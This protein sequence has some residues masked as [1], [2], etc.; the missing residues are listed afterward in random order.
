VALFAALACSGGLLVALQWDLTFI[1]DEWEFLLYRRGTSPEVLLNPHNEHIVLAPVTVYKLLVVSFGMESPLP[2]Q[3]VGD[4]VFLLS[5]ALLFAV[6]RRAAGD[7]L[8]LLG[9]FLV[10]FL[11]PAWIDLLW[12]F[13]I[14]Y[15][16]SIAAGLG[17]LLA[18]QRDDRGGDRAACLLLA[19]SLSFS[20]LGLCFAAAALADLALGPRRRAERAYVPLLPLSLFAIWWLGWGHKAETHLSFDNFLGSPGF[21]FDAASQ[22][23]AS[24]LGLATGAENPGQLEGLLWGQ[25]L[26]AAAVVLLAFRLR[27]GGRDRRWL[28]VALAAGGSFWFLAALNEVPLFREPTNGRYQYPGAVFVLLIAAEALRATRPTRAGLGVATLVA[29]AALAANIAFL[30][31]GDDRFFEPTSDQVR[32]ELAALELARERVDPSFVLSTEQGAAFLAPIDAGAYFSAADSYGSPAFSE[33]ELASSDEPSRAAADRALALALAIRLVPIQGAG[34]GAARP[35][36]ELS[37]RSGGGAELALTAGRYALS[38]P[39]PAD[40]RLLLARF[41]DMPSVE[42]GR[43]PRPAGSVLSIPRDRSSR[44]WRLGLGGGGRI[45]VCGPHLR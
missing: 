44:S 17:M 42:L 18:L 30:V 10:L 16:G 25:I 6:L 12:P 43:L 28:L 40:G 38:A 35:C 41:S 15:S 33:P 8:A 14:G 7:W 26:L 3:L 37:G 22:A 39:R 13:Q 19:V 11:G 5:A 29:A 1:F 32:A 23:I 27:R 24:L 45:R 20:S 21:V 2:F 34:L 36:R 4:L 31:R 9:T